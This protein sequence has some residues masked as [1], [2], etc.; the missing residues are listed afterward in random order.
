M[1]NR[2]QKIFYSRV[3]FVTLVLLGLL[4]IAL[5][6]L[7]FRAALKHSY[8]LEGA[9]EF[10]RAY[11]LLNER[12]NTYVYGMQ[13]I[14]G[15]YLVT[16]FQPAPQRVRKYAEFREFFSNFSGALGMGFIRSVPP[17]QKKLYERSQ[18][19]HRPHFNIQLLGALPPEL[20]LMVVETI[21]PVEANSKAL[22][23]EMNSE[24]NRRATIRRA[25]QSGKPS[26][27]KSLTLIQL[28]QDEVGFIFFLP[29]Y[30]QGYTPLTTEERKRDIVG[31]T[32]ASIAGSAIK[33]Y[34]QKRVSPYLKF[35]VYEEQAPHQFKKLFGVGSLS[36]VADYQRT[37]AVG[38]QDWIV[39]ANYNKRESYEMI[40]VL[41]WFMFLFL[42]T[43]FL[44][45][46]L[47]VR[48][49]L[50]AHPTKI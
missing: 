18:Q 30:R 25:I 50:M 22:G 26:L 37:L 21:E 32:F 42:S 20:D 14:A 38:G 19:V 28:A 8:R 43:L 29:I 24:E 11:S 27:T 31:L 46:C 36:G 5:V 41:P 47:F 2:L 35:A 40:Q 39:R 34:L 49:L 23:R 15:V 7:S 33:K 6:A 9:G 17:S 10:N 16:D 3:T 13:G 44:G 4:I 45:M 12:M 48:R 1:I